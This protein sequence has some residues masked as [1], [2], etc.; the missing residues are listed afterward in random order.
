MMLWLH[1]SGSMTLAS[2]RE[3]IG[4]LILGEICLVTLVAINVSATAV[5]KEREDGSLDIILTTPIQPGPYLA[6]KHRGVVRFLLPMMCVP[7]ASLVLVMLYTFMHGFGAPVNTTMT[8]TNGAVVDIPLIQWQA[9]TAFALVFVPFTAFCVMIG[10]MWSIRSR[11]S[12]GSV[13]TGIMIIGGLIV[14][15][16][17]C[18]IPL[19]NSSGIFAP[20]AATI[21]PVNII[22]TGLTPNEWL[23]NALGERG[24]S[25]I[26][27]LV[28]GTLAAG[29]YATGAVLLHRQMTRTFMM[30]VRQLAG[31]N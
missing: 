19:M 12:I 10:L 18:S 3:S 7:I 11:G 31:T 15:L 17:L 24:I 5:S 20:M 27:L 2:L 25:F 21:S 26:W 30:T 1:A 6:G 23:P 9:V 16:S 22:L 4:F 13:I 8:L 29:C 14:T 28:G